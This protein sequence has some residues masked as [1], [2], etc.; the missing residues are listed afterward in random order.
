MDEQ[1]VAVGV[2]EDREM[3]DAGVQRLAVELDSRILEP[4]APIC[5]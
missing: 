4:A 5:S 2:P 3:A 1:S